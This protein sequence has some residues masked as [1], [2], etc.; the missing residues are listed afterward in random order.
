M[1]SAKAGDRPRDWPGVQSVYA[2]VLD[3][4]DERPGVTALAVSTPEYSVTRSRSPA[5]P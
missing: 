5:Q 1:S 3:L 4:L 2:N